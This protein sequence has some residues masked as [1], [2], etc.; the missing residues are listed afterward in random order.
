MLI[1]GGKQRTHQR[2]TVRRECISSIV[3]V[4]MNISLEQIWQRNVLEE[5][6]ARHKGKW[7]FIT[8]NKNFQLKI[9]DAIF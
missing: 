2:E 3:P 6:K 1:W 8:K 9:C 7:K 5:Y 4:T